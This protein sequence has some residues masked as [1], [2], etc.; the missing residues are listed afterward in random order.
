MGTEY[1]DTVKAAVKH[2]RLRDQIRT[3]VRLPVAIRLDSAAGER[4]TAEE[5]RS[6]V[7]VHELLHIKVPNHGKLFRT[8]LRAYLGT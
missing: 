5:F 7:I 2:L 1:L 6:K 8:L 4:F 3:I